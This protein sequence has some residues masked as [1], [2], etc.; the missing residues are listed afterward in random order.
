M[1]NET[2][3]RGFKI[4]LFP[5][6]EQEELMWKHVNACRFIWNKCKEI[7]DTTYKNDGKRVGFNDIMHKLLDMKQ[8]YP[9][10]K[11]VSNATLQVTVIDLYIAYERFFKKIS[12]YP[13][14][15]SKKKSVAS[16]P[17]R[18]DIHATYIKN[19]MYIKIPTIGL[20]AYRF[21]YR[22]DYHI[23]SYRLRN[24]RISYVNGKWILGV[25]LECEKQTQESTYK[26]MGIDLG[27]KYLATV[28]FGHNREC[29]EV[30]F[31]NI[32][33]DIRIKK[34]ES[35]IKHLNRKFSRQYR[36]NK[37]FID[38]NNCYT[39]NMIK[40]KKK[41]QKAYY[42]IHCIRTNYMH[43]LSCYLVNYKRPSCITMETLIVKHLVKNRHLSK[44][45]QDSSFNAFTNM[46]R[47]KCERTTCTGFMQVPRNYPSSKRCSKCGNIK[48]NLKLGDRIYVCNVCGN[49]IDRDINA[50]RNL[51]DYEYNK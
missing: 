35:K 42:R 30:Q 41:I 51:R 37:K 2:Y 17:L 44:V 6:K 7:R 12:N 22:K 38:E 36:A 4:R 27:I 20:V 48:T 1:M 45:I 32:N 23:V 15:K 3:L 43:E 14:Y 5:T 25:A 31:I 21:D 34:L 50:A 29:E 11:E 13:K 28:S 9:F 49:N 46:I 8:E 18:P 33:K 19:D 16:F 10:L 39:H 24:P 26:R 40:T 47:Y